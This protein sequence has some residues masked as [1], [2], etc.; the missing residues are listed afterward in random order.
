MSLKLG[1]MYHDID[2]NYKHSGLSIGIFY[3]VIS[4]QFAHTAILR[5]V[6]GKSAHNNPKRYYGWFW[7]HRSSKK[8]DRM[9]QEAVDVC[10]LVLKE[11]NK[12]SFDSYSFRNSVFIISHITFRDCRVHIFADNLS[13]NSCIQKSI[14][15]YYHKSDQLLIFS[16]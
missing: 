10:L 12:R 6:V 5:K 8:F 14:I 7:V 4:T 13:W 11:G 15:I 1:N 16:W 2:Y 3:L 9:A